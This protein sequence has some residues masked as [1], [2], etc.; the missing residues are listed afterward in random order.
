[1]EDR[2]MREPRNSSVIVK[3]LDLSLVEKQALEKAQQE[4]P[5]VVSVKTSLRVG[6]VETAKGTFLLTDEGV[7]PELPLEAPKHDPM[8]IL[9]YRE[10]KTEKGHT[11]DIFPYVSLSMKKD[12]VVTL[13]VIATEKLG[14]FIRT[15]GMRLECNYQTW[16]EVLM[17]A[18]PA[19]LA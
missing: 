4:N 9:F 1:M 19:V 15:F 13:P 6:I 17:A 3:I 5:D 16:D 11:S 14:D 18:R 10:T 12:V 7:G 2:L 8:D